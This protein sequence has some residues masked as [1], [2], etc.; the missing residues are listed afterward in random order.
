[1]QKPYLDLQW[2]L[3]DLPK[4]SIKKLDRLYI[5]DIRMYKMIF[6]VGIFLYLIPIQNGYKRNSMYPYIFFSHQ[7]AP[8]SFPILLAVSVNPTS[9]PLH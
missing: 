7:Q 6:F 1:M 9:I 5:A 3:F 4:L 8:I 2:L